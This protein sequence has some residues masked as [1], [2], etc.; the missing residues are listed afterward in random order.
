MRGVQVAPSEN[1]VV[2]FGP[3]PVRMG[4][5]GLGIMKTADAWGE[6]EVLGRKPMAKVIEFYVP[7]S[8]RKCM[9]WIPSEQRGKVIEFCPSKKKT[10]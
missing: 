5:A 9:K 7:N 6:I 1:A 10:A 2:R 8:F 4:M 3:L